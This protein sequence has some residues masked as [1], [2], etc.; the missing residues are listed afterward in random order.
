MAVEKK[1][2]GVL[3]PR[4]DISKN[5]AQAKNFT[6][7]KGEIIVYNADPTSEVHKNKKVRFKF[8]DGELNVDALPFFNSGVGE[9]TPE[10]GEIFNDYENN[11]AIGEGS[12]ARGISTTAGTKAFKIISINEPQSEGSPIDI[13]SFGCSPGTGVKSG[14]VLE[15]IDIHSYPPYNTDLYFNEFA[16]HLP[17]FNTEEESIAYA[18]NLGFFEGNKYKIVF[19]VDV[20]SSK[21]IPVSATPVYDKSGYY[22]TVH[23]SVLEGE[24]PYAIGD[25]LQIEGQNHQNNSYTIEAIS[26][27]GTV[28]TAV[29][30]DDRMAEAPTYNSKEDPDNSAEN[31]TFN[32]P[33]NWLYVAGK[34]E[35][36]NGRISPQFVG[37]YAGGVNSVS[38]SWASFAYG[39][40]VKAT[41]NY[42]FAVGRN[43][44][45]AYGGA[46]FGRN[47]EAGISSIASGGGKATGTGC[48]ALGIS[49]TADFYGSVA[50]GYETKSHAKGSVA[51]GYGVITSS[52]NKEPSTGYNGEGQVIL[53]RFN[54]INPRIAFAV[55]NGTSDSNRSNIFEVRKDGKAYTLDKKLVTEDELTTGLNAKPGTLYNRNY[56]FG[57]STSTI[58]GQYNTVFGANNQVT[59]GVQKTFIAG[60]SNIVG[61]NF[62]GSLGVR[63][64]VNHYAAM[65]FGDNLTTSNFR[66]IVVGWSN[67]TDG[68]YN[69]RFVVGNGDSDK[70]STAFM[71][72]QDGSAWVK[73]S[74]ESEHS[75]VNNSKLQE[76]CDELLA[77]IKDVGIEL[78]DKTT[79][80]VYTLSI[81]N[82]K[83]VLE[84]I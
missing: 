28:M 37:A 46:A 75:V 78:K 9:E 23:A 27:D 42:A 30:V 19:T 25:L 16:I 35:V 13:S 80:T 24:T 18:N 82:G 76:K 15:L 2:K 38:S 12:T 39:R 60:D 20:T 50:L 74:G 72:M 10:G 77:S 56:V 59:G 52:Q 81:D 55:G 1:V 79:G 65:T 33:E 84:S 14:D 11:K 22:I 45:A 31:P 64:T 5:W 48:V 71:V 73:E 29:K 67:D 57:N 34:N 8:G 51:L 41:G 7:G 21:G 68:T 69:A 44:L 62:A 6:P 4:N 70:K 83:L 32:N 3:I 26:E 47:S 53:G 63:N 40:D 43:T 49:N 36:T 58:K 17:G 54:T 66:Q 61:S